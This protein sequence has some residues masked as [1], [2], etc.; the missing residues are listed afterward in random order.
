MTSKLPDHVAADMLPAVECIRIRKR[1]RED[2]GGEEWKSF[3]EERPRP[4]DGGRT[5]PRS[6]GG[7]RRLTEDRRPQGQTGTGLRRRGCIEGGSGPCS[8]GTASCWPSS[9]WLR[10]R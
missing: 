2:E 4:K 3:E 7:R 8:S 6:S 1:M 9:L 5:S 10:A